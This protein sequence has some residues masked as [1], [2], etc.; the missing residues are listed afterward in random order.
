MGKKEEVKDCTKT[1]V[2]PLIDRLVRTVGGDDAGP[3]TTNKGFASA[4]LQG[5]QRD[6]RRSNQC[7]YRIKPLP[8]NPDEAEGN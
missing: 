7:M 2:L 8:A 3:S 5:I 4:T 1:R 6:P